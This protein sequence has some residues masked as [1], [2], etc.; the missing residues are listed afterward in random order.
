MDLRRLRAGEWMAAV[1]GVALVVG[2][3]LPWYEVSVQDHGA[4][5]TIRLSAWEAYSAVDILLL[6][7]GVLA[8]GLLVVTAIQRT[9]AV[10]IAADAMLTIFAGIVAAVATIRVLNLPRSLEPPAGLPIETGR[11]AIAWLGLLAVYGVLAGAIL[12]MR[13][14]RFS[15]DGELTDGTGV[16]VEAAP[17]IELLPAPPRS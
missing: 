6:V 14:E 2:L 1:S 8:V 3:F 17:E 11:T 10:G 4:D 12:A 5:A 9:A 16:P 13:D 7:L 15:R